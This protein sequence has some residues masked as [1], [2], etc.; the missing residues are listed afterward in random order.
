METIYR[1]AGKRYIPIGYNNIPDISDGIWLVQT[2]EHSKATTSLLWRVG[3]LKRPV[4]VVT[5]ASLMSINDE[6]A[7]YL[8]RL[9]NI[10]SKEYLE[11]KEILGGYLTG[12]ISYGGISAS[13]L[14]GLFLR[15]IAID[16]ESSEIT[17][18]DELIYKFREQYRG[19]NM[20]VKLLYELIEWFKENKYELKQK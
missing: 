1:K 5:H 4:D 12:N 15:Q 2:K 10:K 6:L 7:S 3:E 18:W 19:S 17:K 9:T 13:D 16:L 11:A 8:V 14:C 20:N